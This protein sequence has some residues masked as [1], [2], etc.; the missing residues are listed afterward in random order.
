MVSSNFV[1]HINALDALKLPGAPR[2]AQRLEAVLRIDFNR[3]RLP[4]RVA[5]FHGA[6][7]PFKDLALRPALTNLDSELAAK[8]QQARIKMDKT[9]P[10]VLWAPV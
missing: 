1:D 6:D 5:A 8:R 4:L 10:A 9:H 2:L 3:G 7:P